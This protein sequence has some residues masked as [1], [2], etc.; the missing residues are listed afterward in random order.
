MLEG[1]SI[2]K[3]K[4]VV[5]NSSLIFKE[6]DQ[7]YRSPRHKC[8]VIHNGYNN[9]IFKFAGSSERKL[10]KSEKNSQIMNYI[11]FFVPMGGREKDLLLP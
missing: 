7:F 8:K 6:L 10:L 2:Q 9:T 1:Y 5:P 11:F 4:F 3:S